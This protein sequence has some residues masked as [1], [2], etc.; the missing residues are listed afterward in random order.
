[1]RYEV[2]V[3]FWFGGGTIATFD[4]RE[5]AEEYAHALEHEWFVESVSIKEN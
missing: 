2:T 4:T 5:E 3:M 1:M